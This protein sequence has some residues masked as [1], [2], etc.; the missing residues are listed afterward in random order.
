MIQIFIF[1][2]P[3][4]GGRSEDE[5]FSPSPF[6]PKT[7]LEDT[8]TEN[9]L[10]IYFE[11]AEDIK[12]MVP[13]DE[14]M[15]ITIS[16]SRYLLNPLGKK[17]GFLNMWM[18]EDENKEIIGIDDQG[19]IKECIQSRPCVFYRSANERQYNCPT[20]STTFYPSK[21]DV[22]TE[23]WSAVQDGLKLYGIPEEKVR[24]VT[25]F[26]I[27]QLNARICFSAELPQFRLPSQGQGVRSN[28]PFVFI[29]GDGAI[30]N[31]FRAG[32]GLNTGLKSAMSLSTALS[33]QDL[34]QCRPA[35]FTTYNSDMSALQY[36]EL[37]VRSKEMMKGRKM[38]VSRPVEKQISYA[39]DIFRATEN[40]LNASEIA[41]K[42]EKKKNEFLMKCKE[43]HEQMKSRIPQTIS[44]LSKKNQ[45]SL[46]LETFKQL[47]SN[48]GLDDQRPQQLTLKS[49]YVICKSFPWPNYE[50]GGDEVIIGTPECDTGNIFCKLF[51][52]SSVLIIHK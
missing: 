28:S 46:T 30:Q 32:R 14:G 29:I 37:L 10:G 48:L 7:K 45:G 26:T 24:M 3:D 23:V 8:P 19:A 20:H 16:Q 47:E 15:A 40:H 13:L 44:T 22:K 12:S 18:A 25:K 50:V 49:V 9:I 27:N 1:I 31:S 6:G 35:N 52:C 43:R 4:K 5:I 21:P 38:Q 39:K 17:K 2:I 11:D 34:Y 51:S 36:R 42:R 41:M 33:M